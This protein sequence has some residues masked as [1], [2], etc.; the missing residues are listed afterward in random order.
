M[1][2]SPNRSFKDVTKRAQSERIACSGIWEEMPSHQMR[3]LKTSKMLGSVSEGA[4]DEECVAE[5]K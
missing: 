4:V 1:N 5:A 2:G 3:A